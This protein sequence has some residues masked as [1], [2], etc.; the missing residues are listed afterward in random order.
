MKMVFELGRADA[1]TGGALFQGSRTLS[2]IEAYEL[3][4][5]LAFFLR[6]S[7]SIRWLGLYPSHFGMCITLLG[8]VSGENMKKAP[9]REKKEF[10]AADRQRDGHR[11]QEF[12]CW[13]QIATLEG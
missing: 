7:Q 12:V 1:Y 10:A 9:G 8:A 6:I 4:H 2:L 3:V 5:F 13:V 11:G